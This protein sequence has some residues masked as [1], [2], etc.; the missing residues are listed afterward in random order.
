MKRKNFYLLLELNLDPP[1]SDPEVIKETIKKKQAEWSRYRNHPTRALEAKHN[2]DLIPEI[3]KTMLSEKSR[4]QEARNALAVI[5]NEEEKRY[6]DIDRHIGM[7]LR[8]GYVSEEEIKRLSKLH[9]LDEKQVRNRLEKIKR[10]NSAEIEQHLIQRMKKGFVTN[11]DIEELAERFAVSQKD[12]RSQVTCPVNDNG[13]KAIESGN[14]YLD[15]TVEKTINENLKIIGKSS[16]YE[17]LDLPENSD[18]STLLKHS[19]EKKADIQKSMRKDAVMTA[20]NAL[21]GHCFSLFKSDKRRRQYDLS[22]TRSYLNVLNSDIDAVAMDGKIRAEYIDSLV[23]RAL[24]FGMTRV[25]A[26]EYLKSYCRKKKWTIETPYKRKKKSLPL[27]MIAAAMLILLAGGGAFFFYNQKVRQPRIEYAE[28]V[29]KVREHT[30]FP[31]K[32]KILYHYTNTHDARAYIAKAKNRIKE[33]QHRIDEETFREKMKDVQKALSNEEFEKALALYDQLLERYPATE[34]IRKIQQ[35]KR[36]VSRRIEDRDYDRLHNEISVNDE[37]DVKLAA[38]QQFIQTYPQSS[39][40]NAV[41]KLIKE[42]RNEYYLFIVKQIA[43]NEKKE[44]WQQCAMYCD[45]FIK[46]Y[47]KDSRA[48]SLIEQRLDFKEKHRYQRIINNLKQKAAAMG[49]DLAAARQIFAD[50]LK[51]YPDSV[52]TKQVS[53]AL[54]GLDKRI[55]ARKTKEIEK[56]ILRDL[57]KTDGRFVENSDGTIV[58]KRTGLMWCLMD[59]MAEMEQCMDYEEAVQYVKRLQTGAYSDWRLPTV[60]ELEMFYKQ[61][62]AFPI[63]GNVPWYWTSETYAL[64]NEGWNKLIDVFMREDASDWIQTKK[65][66]WECG[67]VRAVRP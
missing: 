47:P 18:L 57:E 38:F 14:G 63:N 53:Q 21:I 33:I 30:E 64:Y 45:Q 6:A 26:S 5:K 31:E 8:K 32:L 55:L 67:A 52:I 2:I 13:L 24:D 23:D 40:V 59:S 15:P 17:F 12:I 50:Y 60:R 48:Q 46:A 11:R 51:A 10:K 35:G 7:C 56:S 41:R 22:R 27:K 3:Q 9:S 54:A 25:E 28:M 19:Q 61:Q 37:P 16:L 44:N 34:Y 29:Q 49:D 20:S 66:N 1:E 65:K 4:L 62:P 58:D 39:H 36:N 43:L 42:M